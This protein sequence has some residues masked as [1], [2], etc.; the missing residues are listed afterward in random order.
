[1]LAISSSPDYSLFLRDIHNN[2]EVFYPENLVF[3]P[4]SPIEVAKVLRLLEK[5]NFPGIRFLTPR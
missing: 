4:T 1:M 3:I 2:V 5:N